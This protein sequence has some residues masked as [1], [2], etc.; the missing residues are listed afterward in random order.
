MAALSWPARTLR[1]SL[2]RL[3]V[4][5]ASVMIL[6]VVAGAMALVRLG[7]D[8]ASVVDRVD[9]A[10]VLVAQLLTAYVDQEIGVRGYVLTAE[11]LFLQPY[12]QGQSDARQATTG[13]ERLLSPRSR[14]GEVLAQVRQAG[15]AWDSQFAERAVA[16]TMAGS[17]TYA[18]DAAQAAGKALFDRLRVRVAASNPTSDR[19]GPRPTIA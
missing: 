2:A 3:F 13:L 10:N 6:A 8:R 12:Q 1:G 11:P 7:H 16:A 4:V 19:N 17:T 9:P 14:G 18:T 15:T 5:A